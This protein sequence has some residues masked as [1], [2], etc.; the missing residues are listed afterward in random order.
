MPPPKRRKKVQKRP[1]SADPPCLL[2]QPQPGDVRD[3]EEHDV[4]APSESQAGDGGGEGEEEPQPDHD[5]DDDEI[6][7]ES[8]ADSKKNM[9]AKPGRKKAVVMK[10]PSGLP[11]HVTHDAH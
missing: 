6:D 1:S 8:E 9:V 7:G 2:D 11:F 3:D 4:G 10:R 5:D